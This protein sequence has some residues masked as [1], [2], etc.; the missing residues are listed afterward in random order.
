[1]SV[2]ANR[3]E[4][5]DYLQFIYL[6]LQQQ[7]LQP[8]HLKH[9]CTDSVVR[10]FCNT[11]QIYEVWRSMVWCDAIRYNTRLY[12]FS[13]LFSAV[14]F[15]L[16]FRFGSIPIF[17]YAVWIMFGATF[18]QYFQRMRTLVLKESAR[19]LLMLEPYLVW[20]IW[21]S[22]SHVLKSLL[23]ICIYVLWC[24]CVYFFILLQLEPFFG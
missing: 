22:L 13:I 12:F 6:P 21:H 2:V 1:M 8:W 5:H 14:R 4:M 10:L 23:M 20:F 24:C 9:E 15:G 17:L 3:E 11:L 16:V 19:V 18:V 7:K